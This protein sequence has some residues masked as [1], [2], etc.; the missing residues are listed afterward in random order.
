MTS[1]TTSPTL[2]AF[3]AKGT[4]GRSRGRARSIPR[5]QYQKRLF[6]KTCYEGERGKTTYLSHNTEE[7]NCPSKGKLNTLTDETLP[8]EVLEYEQETEESET[9]ATQVEIPNL[10]VINTI[11][12]GLNTLKPVPTQL[13]TVADA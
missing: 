7:Y 10:L 4:R 11:N 2:A 3:N 12:T 8:P 13:L 5:P 6:C 1:S 9:D